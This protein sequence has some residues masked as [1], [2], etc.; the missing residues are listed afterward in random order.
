MADP[1]A[2]SDLVTLLSLPVAQAVESNPQ[3]HLPQLQQ[4]DIARSPNSS[5]VLALFVN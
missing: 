1:F 5:I 3:P 4:L 2:R